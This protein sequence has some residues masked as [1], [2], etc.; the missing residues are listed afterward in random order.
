MSI[1]K[2][3]EDYHKDKIKQG[4]G[5]DVPALDSV[6]RYKQGQFNM[7]N[8]FDNVGKTAWILW[9]F[10]CLATKYKIKFC[11]WSG[12]NRPGM[13]MRQLIEWY[14]GRKLKDLDLNQIY[15][16]EAMLSE[17]FYFV[18]NDKM[19]TNKELYEQAIESESKCLLIDPYTGL[20]RDYTHAGNYDFLNETREFCNSEKITVY[21]NTHPNTEAAR[22][23]YTKGDVESYQM[24]PSRSQSEGGQPFANRC[25]DFITI[26]R[27]VG[28]PQYGYKTHIYTRK[29]KDTETGGAVTP[30]D[31]PIA[32]EWNSGLGFVCG[33]I[34]PLNNARKDDLASTP[35]EFN[36]DFLDND[37]VPF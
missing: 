19:W 20:N 21:V 26:H 28:H 32:F 15:M 2:Y 17:L 13:L 37:E 33:G 25:D 30:M 24:P 12:E 35:I 8:G 23:T 7:I 16:Y 18:S 14:S 3:L 10:L 5:I 29:I 4:L 9:Y 31:E 36:N 34:N 1:R 27:L 6:L 11:I 22:R